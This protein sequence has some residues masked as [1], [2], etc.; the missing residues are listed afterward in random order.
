[1][2]S[3]VIAQR[4]AFERTECVPAALRPAVEVGYLQRFGPPH[5]AE[6]GAGP[7]LLQIVGEV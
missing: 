4:F 3:A 7:R 5:K 6:F 2:T 1:M